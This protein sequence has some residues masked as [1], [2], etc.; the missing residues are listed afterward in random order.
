MKGYFNT[1]S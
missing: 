1:D